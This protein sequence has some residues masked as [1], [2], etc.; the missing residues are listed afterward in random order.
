MKPRASRSR[1][2]FERFLDGAAGDE[3]L[4]HK[5]HGDIDPLADDRFAA[6]RNEPGQRGPEG[7]LAVGRDE[8][9]GEDQAPGRGVDEKRRTVPDVGAP[10]AGRELVAN[11]RVAGGG[12]GNAQER[13]G[14][15]HQ[16]HALLA[17]KRIFVDET[18]DPARARLGAQTRDE[19]ARE[20]LDAPRLVGRDRSLFEEG[21]HAFGLGPPVSRRDRGAE[22]RLRDNLLAQR[23]EGVAHDSSSGMLCGIGPA[24][25]IQSDKCCLCQ[26]AVQTQSLGQRLDRG[27]WS[28]P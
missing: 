27:A 26:S 10:V 7:L 9:P 13:F 15:A 24:N 2:E 18:F 16:R 6:P 1:L 14:Q 12:V 23:G 11:E 17:R 8:T 19:V 3:L 25:S 21:D 22:R 4:A 20:P 5:P 28:A